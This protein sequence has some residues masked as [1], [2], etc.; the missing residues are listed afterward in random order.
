M[1]STGTRVPRG[2]TNLPGRR[3]CGWR[4]PHH[5]LLSPQAVFSPFTAVHN[6]SIPKTTP[7][8]A[9][10]LAP[11]APGSELTIPHHKL[12]G[13]GREGFISVSFN[14][15]FCTEKY[16]FHK[17]LLTEVT[18]L[19]LLLTCSFSFSFFF[20]YL[21]ILVPTHLS[22]LL[23]PLPSPTS[24]LPHIHTSFLNPFLFL[25]DFWRIDSLPLPR[26]SHPPFISI[27][28]ATSNKCT[29]KIPVLIKLYCNCGCL[30]L[31]RGPTP[32]RRHLS[33]PPQPLG[34]GL[35]EP[36]NTHQ[37][38]PH[39]FSFPSVSPAAEGGRG[40]PHPS[41]SSPPPK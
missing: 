18:F 38:H 24:P 3:L 15:S 14:F 22:P 6:F 9:H 25:S 21:P 17:R 28:T 16:S 41:S 1:P 37:P 11:T 30:H 27:V 8:S 12:V 31:Q 35:Q 2:R 5:V 33:A 23:S 32:P 34:G 13:G 4:C 36:S 40:F 26:P 29:V 7:G 10:P 39:L 20:I 19:V